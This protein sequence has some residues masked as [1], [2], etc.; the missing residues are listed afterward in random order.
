M[1]L[2]SF[3]AE[4]ADP[5]RRAFRAAHPGRL[6]SWRWAFL[7]ALLLAAV[8]LGDASVAAQEAR[9]AITGLTA[10]SPQPGTL[11]VTWDLANPEP[12]DYR[13]MWHKEGEPTPSWRDTDR[14]AYTSAENYT[15]TGLEEDTRYRVLVRARY[16]PPVH[17]P[18]W[19]GRFANTTVRT[20]YGIPEEPTGLTL[21]DVGGDR[22]TL[23]W[24]APQGSK[25]TGYRVERA[26]GS[27][28]AQTVT[29]NTGSTLTY[30]DRNLSPETTYTYTVTA[31]NDQ[32]ESA[33][34]EPASVTTAAP[35]VD[36]DLPRPSGLTAAYQDGILT[37]DWDDSEGASA[38]TITGYR[39]L[40]G[41]SATSLAVLEPDTGSTTTAFTDPSA[42]P[43]TTYVY[44][45][46]SRTAATMSELSDT[47]TVAAL[48]PPSKLTGYGAAQGVLLTWLPPDE[49]ATGYRVLRGTDADSLETL[50]EDT[51]S[52]VGFYVDTAAAP[53]T[54]YFYA[55]QALYSPGAG[56]VSATV[57]VL[58][59]PLAPPSLVYIDS[60]TPEESSE[61]PLIAQ[62][63]NAEDPPLILNLQQADE[64]N[65]LS[66]GNTAVV[67][68]ATD[69]AQ[70]VQFLTGP[71]GAT[72][73]GVQVDVSATNN[74]AS[75]KLRADIYS[76][77]ISETLHNPGSLVHPIG[78]LT[79]PT[80][81]LLTIEAAT[82]FTLD[83][84]TTYWLVLELDDAPSGSSV[85]LQG[86]SSNNTDA[87]TD[88]GW[89]L[90][91]E[92]W[93]QRANSGALWELSDDEIQFALLG[94][95]THDDALVTNLAQPSETFTANVGHS[96]SPVVPFEDLARAVSFRTGRHPA[97]TMTGVR[98]DVDLATDNL[99]A[100]TLKA[101]LHSDADGQP[102]SLIREVGRQLNPQVGVLDLTTSRP[103]PLRPDTTYW[104]VFDLDDTPTDGRVSF[105]LSYTTSEDR[106]SEPGWRIGDGTLERDG[107]LDSWEQDVGPL[108]IAVLGEDLYPTETLASNTAQH[109]SVFHLAGYRLIGSTP[110]FR[111]YST[112]FTTG[113]D[114]GWYGVEDVEFGV[115][116]T[117]SIL[118]ARVSIFAAAAAIDPVGAVSLVQPTGEPIAV[119]YTYVNNPQSTTS[120]FTASFPEAAVLDPGT[121]YV[122]VIEEVSGRGVL[123]LA[124]ANGSGQLSGGWSIGDTETYRD[125]LA[126]HHNRWRDGTDQPL[127]FDITGYKVDETPLLSA[128]ELGE[129]DPD[130]FLRIGKETI[131]RHWL[132]LPEGRRYDGRASVDSE[133]TDLV[134]DPAFVADSRTQTEI[135]SNTAV[136]NSWRLCTLETAFHIEKDWNGGRAFTTGGNPSGYTVT[137]VGID[138][139][140]KSGTITP[141][142]EVYAAQADPWPPVRTGSRLAQYRA[143]VGTATAGTI[144]RFDPV[145][146]GTRLQLDPGTEYIARFTNGSASGRYQT[147]NAGPGVHTAHHGWE[148]ESRIH[149]GDGWLLPH[150][151]QG[152]NWGIG[153]NPKLLPLVVYGWPN[154]PSSAPA[155]EFAVPGTRM[156]SN[157]G[158]PATVNQLTIGDTGSFDDIAHAVAFRTGV[159]PDG[160]AIRGLQVDVHQIIPTTGITGVARAA[161]YSDSGGRP[162]TL[163]HALGRRPEVEMGLLTFS[164]PSGQTL[165]GNTTYW[166]VMEMDHTPNNHRAN[167]P[168]VASNAHDPCAG[169]GWQ[170]GTVRQTRLR[171]NDAWIP[172]TTVVETF[173]FAIFAEPVTT[174]S[175]VIHEP[176]CGD[177]AADTSTTGRLQIDGPA[178][179][180]ILHWHGDEDWFRVELE[181]DT[182]Y[183]FD[184][185]SWHQDETP[186]TLEEELY[187]AGYGLVGGYKEHWSHI[188]LYDADGDEVTGVVYRYVTGTTSGKQRILFRPDADGTYYVGLDNTGYQ[189]PE[190]VTHGVL[191]RKDDYPADNTTTGVV[192]VGGL[193]KNY[194]M[195][196]SGS[197]PDVDWIKVTLEA[198]VKYQFSYDMQWCGYEA[199]IKGIYDSAGARVSE[200]SSSDECWT[201]VWFT[202]DTGGTYYVGLSAAEAK[203]NADESFTPRSDFTFEGGEGILYVWNDSQ[204]SAPEPDGGDLPTRDVFTRGHVAIDERPSSGRIDGSND[205]DWYSTWMDAG[206]TYRIVL[207][208]TPLPGEPDNDLAGSL[209]LNLHR[210]W[211]RHSRDATESAMA[212]R[213]AAT[214]GSACVEITY[215]A[216]HTGVHW[217]SVLADNDAT[218]DY[219]LIVSPV[220]TS[221]DVP[222]GEIPADRSSIVTAAPGVAVTGE[223]ETADD[224]DWFRMPLLSSGRVYLI[225]VL[226]AEARV[227]T[228]TGPG[229]GETTT[230]GTL[231]HT[232]ILGVYD[233]EGNLD[234]YSGVP[235][236]FDTATSQGLT[237]KN[238]AIQYTPPSKGTYFLEVTGFE[239]GTGT[240][241]V[242]VRDI[243]DTTLSEGTNSL[244]YFGQDSH[245]G[246]LVGYV[247]PG[248]PATGLEKQSPTSD[249]DLWRLNVETGRNY[250]LTVTG[251]GV[252]EEIQ[253][254]LFGATASPPGYLDDGV[255]LDAG[256]DFQGEF[257]NSFEFT[258]QRRPV[259]SLEFQ[260]L[261]TVNDDVWG[262]VP[263][264]WHASVETRNLTRYTLLLTDITDSGDDHLGWQTT[265]GA[266]EVGGNATGTINE[267]YD[268]DWF[269]VSLEANKTYRFKLRGAGSDG[270]TLADPY[271]RLTRIPPFFGTP[272][273]TEN[274]NRSE[275]DRDSELIYSTSN[276]DEEFFIEAS[277][278]GAT[279]TGTGTYTIEVE[280]I[281]GMGQTVNNPPTGGPGI[282][283]SPRAGETLT[284]DT[285]GIKDA[286]G[287]TNPG[288]TYQWIRHDFFADTDTD[289]EGETGETYIV[290]AED[291]A[292]K[293]RVTFTDDAGNEETMTSYAVLAAPPISQEQVAENTPP[294]GAP[295]I[296][297][298]AQVG[299]TLIVDIF[300]IEDAD[301]LVNASFAYQWIRRDL[302]TTTDTDIAGET[303][304]TYAVTAADEGKA[305]KV[306]V[307]FTDDAGNEESLT[308]AATGA[309]AG[310]TPVQTD[311][312]YGLVALAQDGTVVLTWEEPDITREGGAHD[313]RI[314][315]NRPEQGEPEPLV[316]VDFT[317]TPATSYTDT[318]VEP[319]VLYVYRVQAV[320]NFFGDLGEASDPV[321]VRTPPGETSQQNPVS[322]NTAA[323]GSPTISGTAQ[324]DETLTAD[325]SGITDADGLANASL[326]YQWL[327]DDADIAGATGTTYVLVAADEG[328]AIKVRV[329]FTDDAG[330]EESLTSEAT[331]AVI[332]APGLSLS[333]LD[334]GTGQEVLASAL[335]QVGDQGRKGDGTKDRAWYATDTPGWHASG[336]LRDGS[337]AW[338]EM[339]LTRVVYFADTGVLRF[340]EADADVHIGE[341]FAEGGVNRELTIW[342]KTETGTVSFL[343]KDNIANSGSC[344]INFTVPDAARPTLAAVAKDDLIIVA[345]SEPS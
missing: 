60:D 332:A 93:G 323:T 327:A 88:P 324:V 342:V 328:K 38:G 98:I 293:V 135:N 146:A 285:S 129:S 302:A 220:Y 216:A 253:F 250:R 202:P 224:K 340:N 150:G 326:A 231:P 261:R 257:F 259:I 246:A 255:E 55:V 115:G 62:Q 174:G 191:V 28:P 110:R 10:T 267:D 29:G 252:P 196:M 164:A 54:T 8:T 249:G 227:D 171:T 94:Q 83:P 282:T 114:A 215:T 300:D 45:V 21:S 230:G 204:D 345:V 217:L 57:E 219:R 19:S 14:N 95:T 156:L 36:T 84:N 245:G 87:G 256:E 123:R 226:G 86:T 287:L 241:T 125:S 147:P 15:I 158:Q 337:L 244:D 290:A 211:N 296:T 91:G 269:K 48:A 12:S 79:G 280:D 41:E 26:T 30:T 212:A 240:Y 299:Q 321:V 207:D 223:I 127:A 277:A 283:G 50:V 263:Y 336:E 275:T 278:G 144:D 266:V 11:L 186:P 195:L 92:P 4:T 137:A 341:S 37:L 214:A 6:R 9:G 183:Q 70:A 228:V 136:K 270:G 180:S 74:A 16:L 292:L 322:E 178:A 7:A 297:G 121:E 167:L 63:Q 103:I 258:S 73:S 27:A 47:V 225:E 18:S 273:A 32:G 319:G 320:V 104:L 325:A 315:R 51:G 2:T 90:G 318:G 294:T 181:A 317:N 233:A 134:C 304:E 197:D 23:R 200:T 237:D 309:V 49:L 268:V 113:S 162:G 291:S 206:R 308:S 165:E 189:N 159:H 34:S 170:I 166:L 334:V 68:A 138:V 148:V 133:P 203:Y 251:Y 343:A 66:I 61:E 112:P 101:E 236:Q 221:D 126:Q 85:T 238:A 35:A 173:K 1:I 182:D 210:L 298:T 143:T 3:S 281:T 331:T 163:L 311:R 274:D 139:D 198:D 78:E 190:E 185:I 72:V 52:A 303:G 43:G 306:R 312:P 132:H 128:H 242:L 333:D 5:V 75:V 77:S 247:S 264:V 335:I 42:V 307:S 179:R 89:S 169:R 276:I 168:K 105:E 145:V 248:L 199:I 234:R 265:M 119:A 107:A 295:Y 59:A 338:N 71:R 284:A 209:R 80:V 81:G 39:I 40:R 272:P 155:A 44:A 99:A 314:L 213:A 305:I 122:L 177:L 344:Y 96:A 175:G 149:E 118:L 243:T 192:E 161:V 20:S 157:L 100:A 160:Y 76:D 188:T 208:G 232:E 262:E 152:D 289:I 141:T 24:E 65:T 82:P 64:T 176:P 97:Y 301:G 130:M 124:R 288:F 142:A 239:M 229:L 58:A 108:K 22:V 69:V 310:E 109:A 218:G 172:T 31:L 140:Q 194:L 25:V 222:G 17:E 271:L 106:S 131:N 279:G 33:A 286:D 330:N 260:A 46:R 116:M 205:G 201:H 13:V 151:I 120:Y 193:K 329:S 56:P 187:W 235:F 67:P 313:Y 111:A 102:G 153:G 184:Q 53:E 117:D 254:F 316:Y 339:T 154:K